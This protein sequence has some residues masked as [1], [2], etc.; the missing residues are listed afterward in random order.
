MM[1]R[2]VGLSRLFGLLGASAF[3]FAVG[4]ARAEEGPKERGLD[5]YFIDVQGGAATLLVTPE[6]ETILVDSG[7]PNRIHRSGEAIEKVLREVA[8]LDRIDHYVTTHW[9]LD[10]WGGVKNLAER[11][12]IKRYW[13]RGMPEDREPGLDFPDGPKE[14]DPEAIAYRAA[15]KGKR[16]LLRAGDALP[17]RGGVSAVVLAASKK[18][19]APK[20]DDPEN[21]LCESAPADH[22]IDNS[23]NARSVVLKFQAGKFD[24]LVCGDLTWNIEKQ[25]VCPRNLVGKVDLYQVT[26][27]G[28]DISNNPIL[29]Q[30]IEPLVTVMTNGPAK[31]G[32]AET[33]H[34]L[35]KIPS[36][37]ASYQLHRNAQTGDDDN[38]D[39]SLIVNAPGK[40]GRFLHVAVSPDGSTFRVQMGQDGPERTF[41]SR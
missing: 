38:T 4:A 10:H 33:V 12:E 37:Q 18:V 36:I 30:T 31:G 34:R 7:W 21:P 39:P 23:D 5:I 14:D 1:T 20:A 11:V 27:H 35:K 13:D 8:G 2:R 25:L 28:L 24:Y 6:R 3:C 40:E 19:I 41:Q 17:L 26:H 32:D 22:P 15:S 29:L 9:H 16:S